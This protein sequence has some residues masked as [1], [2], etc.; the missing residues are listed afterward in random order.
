MTDNIQTLLERWAEWA[1][2]GRH[3][4]SRIG[5]PSRTAESRAGEGSGPSTPGPVVPL[6]F[7]GVEEARV[8]RAVGFLPD[9]QQLVIALQY[10]WTYQPTETG[11]VRVSSK[12]RENRWTEETNMDPRT[13]WRRLKAAE[14]AVAEILAANGV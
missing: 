4:R 5:Y 12:M 9:Q 6:T 14:Q 8:D 11:R 10:R 2:N 1:D 3:T 13:Y 7:S